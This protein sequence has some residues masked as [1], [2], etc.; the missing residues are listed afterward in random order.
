MKGPASVR[1]GVNE[2]GRVIEEERGYSCVGDFRRSIHETAD[3]NV[4]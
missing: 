2:E 3:S 4:E 1:R